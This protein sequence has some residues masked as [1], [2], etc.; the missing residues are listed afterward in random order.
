MTAKTVGKNKWYLRWTQKNGQDV[1]KQEGM[2]F[3]SYVLWVEEGMQL[4]KSK[5]S[6][7]SSCEQGLAC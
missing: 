5:E 3:S 6:G 2:A 7:N 1:E 4:Q